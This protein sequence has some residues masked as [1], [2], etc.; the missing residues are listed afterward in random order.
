MSQVEPQKRWLRDKTPIPI[1]V[2]S[3]NGSGPGTTGPVGR[4]YSLNHGRLSYYGDSGN[5]YT[6]YAEYYTVGSMSWRDRDGGTSWSFLRTGTEE[7]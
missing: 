7:Q 3:C 5:D 1:S 6:W 4:T 2:P